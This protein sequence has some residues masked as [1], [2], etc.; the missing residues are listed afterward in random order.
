M[1]LTAAVWLEATFVTLAFGWA[2]LAVL[3]RAVGGLAD[4]I[5]PSVACLLG[6]VAT[7]AIAST[8]SLLVPI[9]A[10]VNVALLLAAIAIGLSSRSEIARWLAAA[11]RRPLQLLATAIVVLA[12]L[13]RAT[14]EATNYDTGL[15]HAQA[16][17]W[18][19]SFA[20]VPGLGNLHANLAFNSG[21]FVVEALFGAPVAPWGPVLVLAAW[22]F[23]CAAC[24]L[25]RRL[26]EA[27]RSDADTSA[28]AGALLLPIGLLLMTKWFSSPSHDLPSALLVWVAILLALRLADR[29]EL[30]KPSAAAIAAVALATCAAVI[31]LSAAPALLLPLI[32]IRLSLFTR[33]RYAAALVATVAAIVLPFIARNLIL[34]GD[35]IYPLPF[36]DPFSFDWQMPEDQ[37]VRQTAWVLSWARM[38]HR[39]PLEVLAGSPATWL[40]DWALHLRLSAKVFFIATLG[41]SAWHLPRVWRRWRRDGFRQ[42]DAVYGTVLAGVAFWFVTAPDPRFGWPFL[43]L[44]AAMLT[45]RTARPFAAR[46]SRVLQALVL[47]FLVQQFARIYVPPPSTVDLAR[48]LWRPVPYPQPATRLVDIGGGAVAVPLKGNQCWNTLPC[49]PEVAAGL[50]LRG[51]GLASG[52]RIR[53]PS[54]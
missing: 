11:R 16:V 35:L 21:W 8:L 12:V 50:E 54:R 10:G 15:Y 29:N 53:Q 42:S 36:L 41:L 4:T 6:V 17:R 25:S 28:L 32:L 38:P 13:E 49:T 3:R 34:S 5:E 52:F 27:G 33:P 22:C 24:F 26:F 40:A 23:A 51:S 1:I 46:R 20:A 9:A 48:R 14:T 19:Q 45:A 44:A 39:N 2:S 7:M 47:V 30:L 18:I 31:K 43:P 37:V